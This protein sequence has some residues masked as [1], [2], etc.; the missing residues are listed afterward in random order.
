MDVL[1]LLLGAAVVVN[2]V[3]VDIGD[4]TH[5]QHHVDAILASETEGVAARCLA[6][7]QGEAETTQWRSSMVAAIVLGCLVALALRAF[8]PAC[9]TAAQRAFVFCA[10]VLGAYAVGALARSYMAAHV[11]FPYRRARRQ[12]LLQSSLPQRYYG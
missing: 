7:E 10:A 9:T 6:L 4:W 12:L 3:V 1:A 2:L 8:C 5:I 11:T